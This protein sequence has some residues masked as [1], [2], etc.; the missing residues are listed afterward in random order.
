MPISLTLGNVLEIAPVL[1]TIVDSNGKIVYANKMARQE[2]GRT[3]G[4]EFSS[5]FPTVEEKRVN[6]FIHTGL[7]LKQRSP[8]EVFQGASKDH[9]PRPRFFDITS[10]VFKKGK[11]KYLLVVL[12]NISKTVIQMAEEEEKM[13]IGVQKQRD[14]FLSMATHELKNPLA[15]IQAYAKLLEKRIQQ[16]PET[17]KYIKK[18]E[19]G[20]SHLTTLINDLLDISR[21]RTNK[22]SIHKTEFNLNKMVTHLIS[23]IKT[24]HADYKIIKKGTI[25]K[26]VI[27]DED[28][29]RQ[30]LLNLIQN[31]IKYSPKT[32]KVVVTIKRRKTDILVSVKD[33]GIGISKNQQK[34]IFKSFYQVPG[35]GRKDGLGLG[36][37][38]S[39]AIIREHGGLMWVESKISKG[40]TFIFTLPTA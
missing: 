40:S 21:I 25:K 6:E 3:L 15:S 2:F 38:I 17:E 16:S 29:I 4:K 8:H 33:F 32:K 5:L 28:R 35:N 27:G 30:V 36:L 39:S 18:I 14:L 31:A 13:G 23:D 7:I 22:L 10:I 20:T 19:E 24:S 37:F 34:N 11:E 12:N 9:K 1:A 26:A